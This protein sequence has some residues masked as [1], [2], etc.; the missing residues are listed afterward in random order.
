MNLTGVP[1]RHGFLFP[2]YLDFPDLQG[3]S[4]TWASIALAVTFLAMFQLDRATESTAISHLY[5]LP[6]IFAAVRFGLR[7]GLAAAAAS[8]GL[9]H[10]ANRGLWDWHYGESEVLRI[11]MY[12][13]VAI[14]AARETTHARHLHELAMTDDLTGLHNL[15]AFE[16]RLEHMLR[17]ARAR[18]TSLALLVLDLDRLKSLNDVHGHLAGAEAVQKVGHVL[19]TRLPPEAAACR[20]GGDEFVVALPRCVGTEAVDIADDLRRAVN[21]LAPML[22]GIPFPAATISI[23]V[24]VACW[25]D[26]QN[27]TLGGRFDADTAGRALFRAADEALYVAKRGG[28]NRIH[29]D[30]DGREER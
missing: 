17:A 9:Y 5:Y 20:Y 12:M 22:A 15:R 26:G 25:R 28:R 16:A 24:G 13:A 29:F 1:L 3:I 11:S 21:A 7:G 4:R 8:V 27:G 19:A 2:D 18:G 23:S 10:L 14:V 30:G 6:I